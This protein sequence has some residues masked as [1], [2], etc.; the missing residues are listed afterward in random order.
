MKYDDLLGLPYVSNGRIG[1]DPGTD[2]YGY[3]LELC[4][5]NGTPLK[6]FQFPS[7]K[8]HLT[9][10]INYYS[11]AN[12][13]QIE[14]NEAREGDLLQCEYEG[15]LH[16]CYILDKQTVTHMTYSG[17]RVSPIRFLKNKTFLRII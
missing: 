7:G 2:C 17:P 14:A 8:L 1:R 11:Q 5:R 6:D 4:R 15:E 9:E 3:V 13:R 16:I 10:Y 12:V